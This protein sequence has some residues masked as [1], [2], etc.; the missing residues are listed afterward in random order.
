MD[1]IGPAAFPGSVLRGI[2]AQAGHCAPHPGHS[3][4]LFGLAPVSRRAG[5][6]RRKQ[7]RSD[8]GCGCAPLSAVFAGGSD[9]RDAFRQGATLV[10]RMLCLVERRQMG[11]L[12]ANPQRSYGCQPPQQSGKATVEAT[13]RASRTRWRQSFFA[14]CCSAR[15]SC[16]TG[17]SGR[18]RASYRSARTAMCSMLKVPPTVAS[19]VCAAGWSR[20]RRSGRPTPRAVR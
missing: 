12:G 8:R 6:G 17:C 19:T 11:R 10:P 3:A 14:R 2:R 4:R 20:R 1:D 16:L 9:Y 13:C 5:R 15:A 7:A 18:S